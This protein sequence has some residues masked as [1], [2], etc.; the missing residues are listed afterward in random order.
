MILPGDTIAV[1]NLEENVA[2]LTF[3]GEAIRRA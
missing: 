2:G 1:D 3:N